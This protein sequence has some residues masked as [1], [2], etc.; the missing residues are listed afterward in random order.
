MTQSSV[1]FAQ[2]HQFPNFQQQQQQQQAY[3]SPTH[4]NSPLSPS[5]KST[6]TYNGHTTST[7]IVIQSP[8]GVNEA[9]RPQAFESPSQLNC[10]NNG[11]NMTSTATFHQPFYGAALDISQQ[12]WSPFGYSQF[13]PPPTAA[14]GLGLGE[15]RGLAWRGVCT[16]DVSPADVNFFQRW[17]LA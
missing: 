14:L 3:T 15:W 16:H 13:Y 11:P 8:D 6:S 9:V 1:T 4:Y 17:P 12:E 5:G 7:D 2:P 10:A